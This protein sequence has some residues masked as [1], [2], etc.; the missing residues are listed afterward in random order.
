M[1][2]PSTGAYK[3][4]SVWMLRGTTVKVIAIIMGNPEETIWGRICAVDPTAERVG[5]SVLGAQRSV[6]FE[7]TDAVFTLY[8]TRLVATRSHGDS[9][10]LE[11][12]GA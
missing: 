1:T 9:V 10:M 6:T 5:V 3:R 7:M 12:C 8:P 4:L 11:E 2:I